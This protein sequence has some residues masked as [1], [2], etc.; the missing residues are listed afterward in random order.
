MAELLSGGALLGDEDG[1]KLDVQVEHL[2]YEYIEKCTDSRKV[3]AILEV[4]QSGQEG[5]YPDLER[6]AEERLL[7]LL[8]EK[9]R[10]KLLRLKHKTTPQEVAEAELE[11]E[12]RRVEILS[13]DM[14]LL[15]LRG[16]VGEESS[17][18][19][20]G[21]IPTSSVIFDDAR[22]VAAAGKRLPPVRGSSGSNPVS[23]SRS[24]SIT[25][26]TVSTT[27][28]A[29]E[30]EQKTVPQRI[31]GYDWKAW[32]KFDVDAACAEVEGE[33]KSEGKSPSVG[34]DS[35]S[36]AVASAG[37]K[38]AAAH[39]REM[40]HLKSELGANNLSEVQRQTR[41]I[42]EKV[43]GNECHKVGENDEAFACYSRSLALDPT[44]PVVYANRAISCIRLERFELAEDDCTRALSLDK[45]Y[46]KAW[47]RRGMARFKR[48]KYK[49]A[50]EDFEEAAL[51]DPNNAEFKSLA[52]NAAAKYYEVEGRHF[53][54]RLSVSKSTDNVSV[55]PFTVPIVL[56]NDANALL[57]PGNSAIQVAQG[58]CPVPPA[59]PPTEGFT[60]IAICEDDDDDDE[61]EVHKPSTKEDISSSGTFTRIAICEDDDDDENEMESEGEWDVD[62]L[63]QQAL[64]EMGDG[65][66]SMAISVLEKALASPYFKTTVSSQVETRVSLLSL[67]A[68][69][70]SSGGS[71]VKTVDVCSEILALQPS[72]F[73]ALQRRGEALK[74]LGKK[75]LAIADFTAILKIDVGNEQAVAALKE[76]GVGLG[77]SDGKLSTQ[78]ASNKLK[79][80]G[81]E[82]MAKQLYAKAADLYSKSIAL[83]PNNFTAYNNRAQAFIK[84]SRFIEAEQDAA[85]VMSKE[86]KSAPTY[87][88]AAYRRALASRGMGGKIN[89]AKSVQ[90]LEELLRAEPGNK[91]V[92]AELGRSQL[93]LK[94][95]ESSP[96]VKSPISPA[97][98][99][100][101]R[102][103]VKKTPPPPSQISPV[104]SSMPPT[105]PPAP[106][107]KTSSTEQNRKPKSASPASSLRPVKEQE[108]P[109]TPPS[110]L[111]E[112]ERNWRGLKSNPKGFAEY[113]RCFKSSTFK[114]C[115]KEAVSSELLSSMMSA[116]RD[117]S[118]PEDAFTVLAGLSQSSSFDMTM[119]LMPAEDVEAL[120]GVF[121]KLPTGDDKVLEL[122][123]KYK[124]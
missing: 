40:D 87:I 97:L 32:E 72:N 47:S 19:N 11:L 15:R 60:R 2:E 119:M 90:L 43:K 70:V 13:K 21:N 115:F 76:L 110:T 26:T 55:L 100:S 10:I 58:L 82:A 25:S 51:I 94:E 120:K 57:L 83:D 73:K 12:K 81:N 93:L 104:E 99:M 95:L 41:A 45:K 75:D 52:A 118:A 29:S 22:T 103:S 39:K 108:I 107:A 18:E 112:L 116:L 77:P 28:P 64:K 122:R 31:S 113:L 46:I 101:E 35:Y 16:Q 24:V 91:D 123:K 56:V 114:K 117:H 85:F 80:E 65:N 92:K 37:E 59:L 34:L 27:A 71:Y 84:L 79:D 124:L 5:H 36:D 109:S 62:L 23:A 106:P 105:P 98:D 9:E 61:E 50:A 38:R 88:K 89:V 7:A 42:R 6:F 20:K 78:E 74:R 53:P 49:E 63:K 86:G 66:F 3:K 67:L 33:E 8:P 1:R 30:S 4:L 14:Q 48:G 54:S 17:A 121:A 102:V 68:A 44:S 69:A 96:A 111:Y